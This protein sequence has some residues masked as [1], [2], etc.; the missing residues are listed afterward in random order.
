MSLTQFVIC[1]GCSQKNNPGFAQCWKCGHWLIEPT[2]EA[3]KIL[4]ERNKASD[5]HFD[6]CISGVIT[7]LFAFPILLLIA[8]SS[9]FLNP[10]TVNIVFFISLFAM[11]LI[12]MFVNRKWKGHQAAFFNGIIIGLAI[13]LMVASLCGGAFR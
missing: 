11:F 10:H 9:H 12:P 5:D 13:V 1:R 7:S 3:L 6:F 4:Q 2:A 8:W